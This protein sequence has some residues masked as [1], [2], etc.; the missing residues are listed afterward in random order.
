M[1]TEKK[2]RLTHEASRVG[3][4]GADLTV[5]T[6]Q[7]L[8]DD[9][10]DLTTVEGV[11]QA[12]AQEDDEGQTFAQLVGTTGGTGSLAHGESVSLASLN[13]D[14][15]WTYILQQSSALD[16]ISHSNKDSQFPRACRASMTWGLP[17][18]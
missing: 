5:D 18:A 1:Q 9:L 16:I 8:H 10:L 3:G 2:R 7:A 11:L 12:V 17:I 4:V 15:P 14:H 13:L 6:D